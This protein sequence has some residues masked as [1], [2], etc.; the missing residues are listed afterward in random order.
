ME[1]AAKSINRK[2]LAEFKKIGLGEGTGQ[3]VI[4]EAVMGSFLPNGFLSEKYFSG[5]S[6][7]SREERKDYLE[8]LLVNKKDIVVQTGERITLKEVI[9][10]KQMTRNLF[11]DFLSMNLAPLSER[12]VREGRK[13]DKAYFRE[14]VKTITSSTKRVKIF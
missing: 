1:E 5:E 4:N 2:D 9:K 13:V 14:A 11:L 3:L 6:H 10:D 8:N 12:Y 7:L